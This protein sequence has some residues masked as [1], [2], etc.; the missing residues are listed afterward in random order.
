MRHRL[1]CRR[2]N[3]ERSRAG[4]EGSVPGQN[5]KI[6]P[7]DEFRH[8][9]LERRL[10]RRNDLLFH[11]SI[12]LIERRLRFHGFP[13]QGGDSRVLGCLGFQPPFAKG[14]QHRVDP[15]E[16][17]EFAD[18]C[19]HDFFFCDR[20]RDAHAR[21][22]QNALLPLVLTFVIRVLGSSS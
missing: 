12:Q 22:G 7:L 2:I 4:G 17:Y 3:I 16:R 8:S 21:A 5:R 19:G 10:V 1:D 14:R 20:T 13:L 11:Q 15:I 18:D 9:I 6:A